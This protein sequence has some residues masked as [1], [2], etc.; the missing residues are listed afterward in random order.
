MEHCSVCG[1]ELTKPSKN[2]ESKY[3]HCG[4]RECRNEVARH[5]SADNKKNIKT[6]PV[7]E[8]R[9]AGIKKMR[10][11]LNTIEKFSQASYGRHGLQ[12]L[13][14]RYGILPWDVTNYSKELFSGM[15]HGEILRARK[16]AV[17]KNEQ[18]RPLER[19]KVEVKVYKITD[20]AAVERGI[21]E[22]KFGEP[23]S[24]DG[25]KLVRTEYANEIMMPV[26]WTLVGVM[27][28]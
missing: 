20:P 24:Y 7:S 9:K 18:T 3:L 2:P 23:A 10:E 8:K 17:K 26:N 19:K 16:D 25:L 22:H 4:K 14:K 21:K 11:E 5:R 13:T 15:T 27:E 12:N 1:E 28:G 6:R